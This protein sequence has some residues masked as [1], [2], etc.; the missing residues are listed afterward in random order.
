MRTVTQNYEVHIGLFLAPP[1]SAL[2]ETNNSVGLS[3]EQSSTVKSVRSE[4]ARTT[5]IDDFTWIA[6]WQRE[7]GRENERFRKKNKA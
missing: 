3:S 4:E 7:G 2:S 5:D 1:R 6:V